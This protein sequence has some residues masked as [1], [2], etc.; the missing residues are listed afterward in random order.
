VIVGHYQILI[1]IYNALQ[2]KKF[3]QSLK[4]SDFRPET[5]S[6]YRI[7]YSVAPVATT[8]EDTGFLP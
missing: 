8:F 6:I 7:R 1:R 3:E 2:G 5:G 4:E